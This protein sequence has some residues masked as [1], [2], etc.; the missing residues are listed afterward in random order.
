M[1]SKRRQRDPAFKVISSQSPEYVRLPSFKK[2][3]RQRERSKEGKGEGRGEGGR[4]EKE[5]E[6][7]GRKEGRLSWSCCRNLFLPWPH[8]KAG[9]GQGGKWLVTPPPILE[10][11]EGGTV[12]IYH[13]KIT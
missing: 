1:L 2:K 3:K 7:E 12:S 13:S 6:K 8:L 9:K 4:E 10:V 5:G 11:T